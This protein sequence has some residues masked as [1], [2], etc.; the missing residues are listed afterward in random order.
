MKKNRVILFI[1]II[2]GII[3]SFLYSFNNNK[4]NI[5][6]WESEPINDNI[7]NQ[8]NIDKNDDL[9]YESE[10]IRDTKTNIMCDDGYKLD[11]DKCVKKIIK[12]ADVKETCPKGF[13]NINGTCIL[14]DQY[15]AEKKKWCENGVLEGDYCFEYY[16]T[17]A[18]VE[19]VC[20]EGYDYES[21]DGK[22][23]YR[24]IDLEPAKVYGYYGYLV[25]PGSK[26][27]V[28]HDMNYC[29]TREFVDKINKYSCY[30]GKLDGDKCLQK[31]VIDSPKYEY[32]PC[33]EGYT[34]NGICLKTTISKTL[35][36]YSC[37]NGFELDGENC[38]KK[39]TKN[40]TYKE[41]CENGF[42]LKNGKC[43]K[44]IALENNK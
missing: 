19:K 14:N 18:D 3:A 21:E 16:Y 12:L 29:G 4:S 11:N 25:C 32:L 35:K 20:P 7:N 34:G 39:I 23:C 6:K 36:E 44:N 15:E 42:E 27:Q 30:N 26:R 1:L 41:Y 31:W 43:K 8:V 2:L 37:Q 5:K 9:K 28:H 24:F 17:K 38:V 33:K 22:K 13:Q 40:P 10:I